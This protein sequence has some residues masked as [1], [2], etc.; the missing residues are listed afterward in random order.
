M[1]GMIGAVEGRLEVEHWESSHYPGRI[2]ISMRRPLHDAK[3]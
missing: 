3:T 2:W 1:I